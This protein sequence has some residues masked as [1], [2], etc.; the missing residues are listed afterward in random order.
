MK[1]VAKGWYI[2]AVWEIPVWKVEE[3]EPLCA[4]IAIPELFRF[5]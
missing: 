3:A 2:V 5:L 4:M 1:A